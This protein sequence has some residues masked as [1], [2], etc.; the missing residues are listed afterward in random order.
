MRGPHCSLSSTQGFRSLIIE[1]GNYWGREQECLMG[2]SSIM[3]CVVKSSVGLAKEAVSSILPPT[4]TPAAAFVFNKQTLETLACR[5]RPLL[6]GRFRGLV[7]V[8]LGPPPPP[9]FPSD[10]EDKPV[11]PER[12]TRSQRQRAGFQL[13]QGLSLKYYL[14]GSLRPLHREPPLSLSEAASL[15]GRSRGEGKAISP[16]LMALFL[17]CCSFSVFPSQLFCHFFPS[18]PSSS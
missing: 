6:V 3:P 15:E 12:G 13:G 7:P 18:S 8:A 9:Q 5:G 1:N 17:T 2:P 4:P 11:P 14:G 16:L 10:L